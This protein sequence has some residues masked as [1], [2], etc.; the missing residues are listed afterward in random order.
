MVKKHT[1]KDVAK[2]AGVSI[3]TVSFVLNQTPGQVISTKV[4][5]T[6]EAAARKLDYHPSASASGLARKRSG[7]IAIMFY[8]REDL[9]SNHYYSFVVQGAVKEAMKQGFNL[10]FSYVESEYKKGSIL[11][12]I[13]REKNTE[14]IIFIH[15]IDT[16]LVK[17]IESRG[18]PVVAVDNY[19]KMEGLNTV[20]TDNEQGGKEAVLHLAGL[21]HS[22]IGILF[23]AEDRPSIAGRIQGYLSMEKLHNLTISMNRCNSLTFEDG[24][25]ETQKLLSKKKHPTALVCVNDEMAAG[26]IRAAH[27]LGLS[28]PD[29]ISIVGFDNIIMSNYTDPP[30]TTIGSDKEEMGILAVKRLGELIKDKTSSGLAENIIK[31]ELIVRESSGPALLS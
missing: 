4:R 17:D 7:N 2:E 25:K 3:A 9:I 27:S 1:I 13:V 31:I 26:A 12:K 15:E 21:G 11:P 8:R 28:V 23:A 10:M 6:V 16:Q 30:L 20:Q 29:D 18:I 5:D 19:P 14:G 24:F 22:R